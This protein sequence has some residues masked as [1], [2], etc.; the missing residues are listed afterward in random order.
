MGESELDAS[1][2]MTGVV[3]REVSDAL[4]ELA[5]ELSYAPSKVIQTECPIGHTSCSETA[6]CVISYPTFVSYGATTHGDVSVAVTRISAF[7]LGTVSK[8]HVEQPRPLM[9]LFVRSPY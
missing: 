2:T 3:F 5:Q 6:R 1:L 9:R 8:L 7:S 4:D